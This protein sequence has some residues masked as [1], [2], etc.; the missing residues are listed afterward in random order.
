MTNNL[1]M[2]SHNRQMR[3][4]LE[5]CRSIDI[6][7]YSDQLILRSIESSLRYRLHVNV[8]FLPAFRDAPNGST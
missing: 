2:N 3:V 7:W 1:K 6:N 4:G 5:S 8:I